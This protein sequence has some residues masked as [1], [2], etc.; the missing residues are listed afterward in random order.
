MHVSINFNHYLVLFILPLY[1]LLAL[2]SMVWP[3]AF[4]F[5]RLTSKPS[6]LLLCCYKAPIDHFFE[7]SAPA[8]NP[9]FWLVRS[10]L[11][12]CGRF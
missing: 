1:S 4:S 11:Q 2:A 9:S 7:C 3:S 8:F 12:T 10:C 6:Y 5:V